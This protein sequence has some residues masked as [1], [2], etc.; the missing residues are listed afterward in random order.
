GPG[1]GTGTSRNSGGFWC[2]TNWKALIV[3]PSVP[4][5]ADVDD[6]VSRATEDLVPPVRQRI[7]DEPRVVHAA[8]ELR[9]RRVHLPPRQGTAETGVDA[10]APTEVLVVLALG[11]EV[12]RVGKAVRVAVPG[13]VQEEDRRPL[14]D[15]RPGDLDVG[16]GAATGKE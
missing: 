13:R 10:A 4:D 15:G 8:E 3:V 12:V 6:H 5:A 16:K 14:G 2:A 7:D 9:Q 1:S 11:V